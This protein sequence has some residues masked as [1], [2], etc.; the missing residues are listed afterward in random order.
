MTS[1][2]PNSRITIAVIASVARPAS[3]PIIIA[4]PVLRISRRHG[5]ATRQTFK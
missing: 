3:G 5:T 1:G 2:G 4:G